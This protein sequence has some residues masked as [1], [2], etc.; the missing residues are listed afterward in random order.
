M[1]IQPVIGLHELIRWLFIFGV[2]FQLPM[3][4]M[5]LVKMDVIDIKH[6]N[7]ANIFILLVSLLLV[8]LHHQISL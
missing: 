6:T 2:V 8:F 7:I 3:F 4:C 1:Y 5:G